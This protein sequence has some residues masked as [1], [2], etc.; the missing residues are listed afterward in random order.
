MKGLMA[1]FA[2]T[3]VVL[4]SGELAAGGDFTLVPAKVAGCEAS[5]GHVPKPFEACADPRPGV[6]KFIGAC[7]SP[8]S[9]VHGVTF[10]GTTFTQID[11]GASSTVNVGDT[12][13][14]YG[15]WQATSLTKGPSSTIDPG[16]SGLNFPRAC[17]GWRL[18][19]VFSLPGVIT[20]VKTDPPQSG[21]NPLLTFVFTPGATITFYAEPN[22]GSADTTHNPNVPSTI[23]D[24]SVVGSLSVTSGGGNLDLV[25]RDGN[26]AIAGQF[27]SILPGF[28][29]FL[30]VPIQLGT[31][32]FLALTDSNNHIQA[33]APPSG[34]PPTTSANTA[35]G[36]AGFF[37]LTSVP[38]S[39]T[40]EQ[41][42]VSNDGSA[43][44]R[45]TPAP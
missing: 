34:G 45:V 37:G 5:S 12:F 44:F 3:A 35:S 25:T 39:S 38:T 23:A 8:I 31:Q 15:A 36:F 21:T 19:A 42:W 24:G 9:N 33:N 10:V 30:G 2:L 17:R 11:A 14:S 28:W 6:P 18:G 22:T 26:I 27:T 43:S 16:D 13:T 32:V 1:G 4:T 29:E 40:L 41:T 7:I 20:D